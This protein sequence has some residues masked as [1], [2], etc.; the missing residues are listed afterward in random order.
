MSPAGMG[1][2]FAF[3]FRVALCVIQSRRA[4]FIL[5]INTAPWFSKI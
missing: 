5:L 4:S 1:I 2:S 3:P